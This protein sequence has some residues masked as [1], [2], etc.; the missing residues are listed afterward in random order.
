MAYPPRQFQQPQPT[1]SVVDSEDQYNLPVRHNSSRP[2]HQND[3]TNHVSY[4]RSYP[5]P[6][7]HLHG[8]CPGVRSY[9]SSHNKGQWSGQDASGEQ[10]LHQPDTNWRGKEHNNNSQVIGYDQ[11][12]VQYSARK[13]PPGN[14]HRPHQDFRRANPSP[15]ISNHD[16]EYFS[17][18]DEHD[19]A[20]RSLGGNIYP[21]VPPPRNSHHRLQEPSMRSPNGGNLGYDASAGHRLPNMM[22]Q[23]QPSL[24]PPNRRVAGT[25]YS[26]HYGEQPPEVLRK[27][28]APVPVGEKLRKPGEL[29]ILEIISMG[30]PPNLRRRSQGTYFDEPHV[31]RD[32]EL[33]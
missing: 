21:G 14:G 6:V 17:P 8:D 24:P 7:Q 13:P 1:S 19:R 29:L 18:R 26:S 11:M 22:D 3:R 32:Y 15:H 31:P 33:G 20:G 30:M 12:K 2:L 27:T 25:N 23:Q 16:E 5:E 10:E 4:N 9:G 28:R